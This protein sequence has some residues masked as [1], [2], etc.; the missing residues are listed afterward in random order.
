MAKNDVQ[1][2]RALHAVARLEG[3]AVEHARVAG[4]QARAAASKPGQLERLQ[5]L[6]AERWRVTMPLIGGG[7]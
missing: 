4:E 5:V 2:S 6:D 1:Y 3:D 7:R